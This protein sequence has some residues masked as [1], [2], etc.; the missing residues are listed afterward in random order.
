MA[1]KQAYS[2]PGRPRGWKDFQE[3]L[4]MIVHVGDGDIE[5]VKKIN[6]GLKPPPLP[7]GFWL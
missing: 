5:M 7:H 3:G 1:V 4:Q 2:Q 6:G